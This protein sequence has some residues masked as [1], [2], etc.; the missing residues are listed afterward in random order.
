MWTSAVFALTP[1]KA[2]AL[3]SMSSFIMMVVLMHMNM[4]YEYAYVKANVTGQHLHDRHPEVY[5]ADPFLAPI[6]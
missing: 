2:E 4:L 1:V 5:P 6:A 3:E